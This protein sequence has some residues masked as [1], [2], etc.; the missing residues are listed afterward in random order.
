MLLCCQP[1]LF[2]R[3]GSCCCCAVSHYCLTGVVHVVVVLS[4][5]TVWQEWFMLLLCCQPLLFDR[6]GSCC[7]CAV[8]HCCLTGVVHVV[9]IIVFEFAGGEIHIVE[10]GVYC[11]PLLFDRNGSWLSCLPLLFLSLLVVRDSYCWGWGLLSTITAFSVCQRS[12][13]TKLIS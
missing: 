4:A 7:C 9:V 2:D 1:L 11:Q 12:G 3:N 5:I 6:N 8:S 10:V 13:L